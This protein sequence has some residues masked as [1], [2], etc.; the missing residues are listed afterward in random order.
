MKEGHPSHAKTASALS[1]QIPASSAASPRSTGWTSSTCWRPA[2]SRPRSAAAWATRRASRPPRRTTAKVGLR[3]RSAAASSRMRATTELGAWP[4]RPSF[5]AKAAACGDR[6]F[7]QVPRRPWPSEGPRPCPKCPTRVAE[8]QKPVRLG[9]RA[10]VGAAAAPPCQ[11]GSPR[12]APLSPPA[13]AARV[14][15]GLRGERALR[16]PL[17]P[18]ARLA[19][20]APQAPA[21]RAER[22]PPPALSRGLWGRPHPARPRVSC[23]RRLGPHPLPPPPP[24]DAS[25]SPPALGAEARLPASGKGGNGANQRSPSVTCARC[26]GPT[27]TA[28]PCPGRTVAPEASPLPPH[29]PHPRPP[30]RRPQRP[31]TPGPPPRARRESVGRPDARCPPQASPRSRGSWP[32]RALRPGTAGPAAAR[33]S[34]PT[35]TSPSA[36]PA[37][38]TAPPGR[39]GA[40]QPPGPSPRRRRSRGPGARRGRRRSRSTCEFLREREAAGWGRRAASGLGSAFPVAPQVPGLQESTCVGG[41]AAAAWRAQTCLSLL[42]GPWPGPRARPQAPESVSTATNYAPSMRQCRAR[43]EDQEQAWKGMA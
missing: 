18:S 16:P 10:A 26:P 25:V 32:R 40:A 1:S 38:R 23:S 27:R 3:V 29:S 22:L 30:P 12:G 28:A 34:S 2:P 15:A 19:R 7:P 21:S 17:V 35:K 31:C 33:P 14:S 39:T 43:G 20:P 6:P 11:A 9:P 13:A 5:W 4:G 24:P 41:T 8:T 42:P 36:A 37:F